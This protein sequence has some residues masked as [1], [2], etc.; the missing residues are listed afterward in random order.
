MPQSGVLAWCIRHS[1][2]RS[3]DSPDAAA[4]AGRGHSDTFPVPS[5]STRRECQ[6]E[7]QVIVWHVK[8]YRLGEKLT[9]AYLKGQSK[10]QSCVTYF[11]ETLHCESSLSIRSSMP[12]CS[13][14]LSST[15]GA[16]ASRNRYSHGVCLVGSQAKERD[17]SSKGS[18][19]EPHACRDL[20]S[21]C[22][23]SPKASSN[24]VVVGHQASPSSLLMSESV[25]A[26][27]FSALT[28]GSSGH[29]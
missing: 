13:P 11:P 2:P 20:S 21:P 19:Y 28:F 3:S 26:N 17:L 8:I 29:P 7:G 14:A 27:G 15:S 23:D 22:L 18:W 4:V 9:T 12:S 6:T 1:R 24:G 16:G 5:T 25:P 10:G